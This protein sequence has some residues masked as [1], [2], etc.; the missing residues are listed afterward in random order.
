MITGI[1]KPIKPSAMNSQQQNTI[2][3]L[4]AQLEALDAQRSDLVETLGEIDANITSI[5]QTLDYLQRGDVL[6][7]STGGK[8]D[9]TLRPDD[10]KLTRFKEMKLADVIIQVFKGVNGL[11]ILNIENLKD[12]IYATSSEEEEKACRA[13]L[14]AALHRME[15]KQILNRI[16]AG[17]YQLNK[18]FEITSEYKKVTHAK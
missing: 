6:E 4:K 7:V 5:S 10:L 11:P 17:T 13:S 14:T 16:E 2:E 18:E 12:E 9:L 1:S 8:S 15:K 3:Y